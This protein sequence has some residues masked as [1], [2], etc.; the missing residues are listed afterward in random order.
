MYKISKVLSPNFNLT[1]SIYNLNQSFYISDIVNILIS[2]IYLA[3]NIDSQPD[4]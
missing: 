2:T 4:R 1:L 3:I